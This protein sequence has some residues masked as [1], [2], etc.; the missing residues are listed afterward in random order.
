MEFPK[1]MANLTYLYDLQMS[2][3]KF[4]GSIGSTHWENLVNLAFVDLSPNLL[5]G[6]SA[7][8]MFSLPLLQALDLSNNEFSHQVHEFSNVSSLVDTQVNDTVSP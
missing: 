1:W 7:L 6:G 3:N 8:S 5:D 2:E 4:S